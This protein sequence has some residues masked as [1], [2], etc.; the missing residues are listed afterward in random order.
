MRDS[1]IEQQ[2]FSIYLKEQTQR[3]RERERER[4]Y[5]F[6]LP[7]SS[8]TSAQITTPI[9]Y[10]TENEFKKKKTRHTEKRERQSEKDRNA[11]LRAY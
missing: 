1:K 10:K 11:K 3:E 4:E 6:L 2:A 7:S 5:F 8:I 9:T